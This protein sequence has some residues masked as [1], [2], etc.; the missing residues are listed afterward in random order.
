MQTA[1]AP[2][3]AEIAAHA[4]ADQL[5]ADLRTRALAASDSKP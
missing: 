2:V 4:A 1:A 3:T 5:L